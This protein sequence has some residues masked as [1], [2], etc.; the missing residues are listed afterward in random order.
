MITDWDT[1]PDEQ[2]FLG[3]VCDAMFMKKNLALTTRLLQTIDENWFQDRHHK[4]LFQAVF[5]HCTLAYDKEARVTLTGVLDAAEEMS[6][7]QG[8][9]RDVIR[10]CSERAG[11]F[12]PDKF[13]EE[14]TPIWWEK[15]KRPKLQTQLARAD[16]LLTLPPNQSTMQGVRDYLS[17]AISTVDQEPAC[18]RPETDS[19]FASY[20]TFL[21]PLPEEALIPTGMRALDHILGGGLS[22]EGAP[23]GGKL[24]IVTAR[25]GM[26]KTQLALNLGMRVALKKYKV[27]LWSME[28]QPKQIH[29]RLAAALDFMLCRQSGSTIGGSLTYA[30]VSRHLIQNNRAICER[31]LAMEPQARQVSERFKTIAGTHTAKGI[32]NTMRLFARAN[33]DTRLFIIDHLGLLDTGGAGNK[34]IAIGEATR[35]IKTTATELGIDV[36]LLCQLNRSLEMRQEKMPELSDL[37]DSGRIEEDADVVCGLLRPQYYDAEHDPHD[38]QIGILKNRQGETGRFGVCIDNDCCAIYEALDSPI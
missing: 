33:K 8:W 32:A 15:T 21:Q 20:Q 37:R 1:Y 4:A 10:S 6:G 31:Y 24:I 25:P 28:M 22:G 38:L 27:V 35:E 17:G 7:E 3:G 18:L 13:L 11:V 19:F 5:K 16:Q 29:A 2:R 23:A 26:G 14:E 12:E 34:A 9:S 30:M 36:L